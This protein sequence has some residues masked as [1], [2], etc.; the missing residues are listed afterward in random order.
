[1]LVYSEKRLCEVLLQAFSGTKWVFL[2]TGTGDRAWKVVSG[3][4]GISM[5]GRRTGC[6]LA[7]GGSKSRGRAVPSRQF[8]SPRRWTSLET[9][10]GFIRG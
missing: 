2:L 10:Q 5:A 8:L 9:Q 4:F 1:M 6:W 7:S 3:I